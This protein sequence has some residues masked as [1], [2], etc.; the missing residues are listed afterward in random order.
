MV[1]AKKCGA[2]VWFEKPNLDGEYDKNK[3]ATKIYM[4]TSYAV[5]TLNENAIVV[6]NVADA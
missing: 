4:D 2:I 3:A 5:G 6:I 1:K